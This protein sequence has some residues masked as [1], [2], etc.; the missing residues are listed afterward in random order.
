MLVKVLTLALIT[1]LA[2]FFGPAYGQG[3]ARLSKVER[4]KLEMFLSY[5]VEADLPSF[6]DSKPL[7]HSELMRFVISHRHW[8]KIDSDEMG[9]QTWIT[10]DYA[11]GI[12]KS[13]FNRTLLWDQVAQHLK[14]LDSLVV[15]W[16]DAAVTDS[17]KLKSVVKTGNGWKAEAGVWS[18]NAS[19]KFVQI[20]TASFL[21]DRVNGRWVVKA[22]K[23]KKV[24]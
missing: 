11:V 4:E 17:A 21:L 23:R 6:D 2:G 9:K 8:H 20:A 19:D 12:V 16:G 10:E 5:F 22:L 7:T 15:E 18:F 3:T 24:S 14:A 1:S 13:Y